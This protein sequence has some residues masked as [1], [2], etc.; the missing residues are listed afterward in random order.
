MSKSK[1]MKAIYFIFAFFF[2]Q[3]AIE[4]GHVVEYFGAN[5]LTRFI[6]YYLSDCLLIPAFTWVLFIIPILIFETKGTLKIVYYTCS[7]I[8]F[9]VAMVTEFS[10]DPFW[11]YNSI[12]G[13]PFDILMYFIGLYGTIK[14]QQKIERTFL[15]WGLSTDFILFFS[16]K[17]KWD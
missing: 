12:P 13:D 1:V 5:F 11:C 17:K 8:S 6:D 10:T 4:A 14:S 2:S 15:E 16:K 3:I 9:S 7:A